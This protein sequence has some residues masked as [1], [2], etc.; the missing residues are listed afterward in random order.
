MTEADLAAG[1]SSA[2]ALRRTGAARPRL[3]RASPARPDNHDEILS[4]RALLSAAG[5]RAL[6]AAVDAIA[7]VL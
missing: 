6:R 7:R 3:A 4:G 5:K 2:V 1:L